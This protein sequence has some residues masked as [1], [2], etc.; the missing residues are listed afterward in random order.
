MF[1]LIK[2]N[3]L[4]VLIT[5]VLSYS[6]AAV[7]VTAAVLT[8]CAATGTIMTAGGQCRFTPSKYEVTIFEMGVCTANPMTTD[9]F[10]TAGC[11]KT[12][13]A[14]DQTNGFTADMA[15]T[16][17]GSVS[18]TGTSSRPANGTYKYPYIIMKNT[19]KVQATF[20]HSGAT[21]YLKSNGSVTASAPAQD[22]TS[23]LQ[24]FGNDNCDGEY[25]NS[26]VDVGFING[27][28]TNASLNKR[29]SSDISGSSPNRD[30]GSG[31]N[32][33][34]G[35]MEL[36]APFTISPST[37]KMQFTFNITGY[38]AQFF[39]DTGSNSIP[40]A[41]GSGPFSGFFEVTDGAAQ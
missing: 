4:S 3:L 6:N 24:G 30:C 2:I 13:E 14:T 25:L 36:T 28:L 22:L 41:G 34:V 31:T 26:A 12:F 38:G 5:L 40:D 29:D 17:G 16:L 7:A 23:T 37:L 8:A 10:N 32:R 18:L 35:V 21:Y 1:N 9:N 11:S 20:V 15:A 27:Y 19:F 33:L 39:D